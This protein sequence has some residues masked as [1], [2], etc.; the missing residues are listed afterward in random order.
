MIKF[1]PKNM[2]KVKIYSLSDPITNEVMYVG[3]TKVRLRGGI[4]QGFS[5]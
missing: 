1:I 5:V 4:I 3:R 2:D